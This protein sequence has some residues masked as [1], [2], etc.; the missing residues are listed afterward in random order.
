MCLHNTIKNPR[1]I[2]RPSISG[3]LRERETSEYS[4]GEVVSGR[5][6]EEVDEEGDMPC[7]NTHYTSLFASDEITYDKDQELLFD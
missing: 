3:L 1:Y 6:R 4:V 7:N 5:E 2:S